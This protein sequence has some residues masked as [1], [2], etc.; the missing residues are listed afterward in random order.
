M[1]QNWHNLIVKKTKKKLKN[2][3]KRLKLD[4]ELEQKAISLEQNSSISEHLTAS[5]EFLTLKR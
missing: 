3:P 5:V 2:R 4:L 1:F